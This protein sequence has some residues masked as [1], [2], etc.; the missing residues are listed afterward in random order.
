MKSTRA[1]QV[2]KGLKTRARASL[3]NLR[4]G[5]ART[6]KTSYE[7]S[8]AYRQVGTARLKINCPLTQHVVIRAERHF[9][10]TLHYSCPLPGHSRQRQSMKN[11][12]RWWQLSGATQ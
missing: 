3:S 5:K 11:L 9:K 12:L 6:V 8:E 10:A 7:A 2:S 1:R 4:S